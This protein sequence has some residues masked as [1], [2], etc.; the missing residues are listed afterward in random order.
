LLRNAGGTG[1]LADHELAAHGTEFFDAQV[2]ERADFFFD[3]LGDSCDACAV[4]LGAEAVESPFEEID[5]AFYCL[6]EDCLAAIFA[7]K[8]VG[9]FGVGV[10][11]EGGDFDVDGFRK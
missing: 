8:F 11:G 5:G 9:I 6:V 1:D 7:Q 10:A 4:E 3:A 2:Q